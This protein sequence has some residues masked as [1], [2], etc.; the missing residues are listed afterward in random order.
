M[1]TIILD[2]HSFHSLLLPCKIFP[3]GHR[4]VSE[5]VVQ[6]GAPHSIFGV[7]DLTAATSSRFSY[8]DSF[9]DRDIKQLPPELHLFCPRQND[10]DFD[11]YEQEILVDG[12]ECRSSSAKEVLQKI[13]DAK[14]RRAKFMDAMGLIAYD[15]PE[16]E[17]FKNYIWKRLNE[18]LSKCDLCIP[19]YYVAK[20]DMRD[21][22]RQQFEEDDIKSY[23]SII[24]NVDIE[25]I[26]K[27]LDRAKAALQNVPEQKRNLSCLDQASLYSIFEALSCEAF[28]SNES[29]LQNHFDEPFKLIQGKR[30]LKTRDYV[31]AATRFLFD[32]D[33]QRFNWA[34]NAWAKF[35]RA[36]TDLEW[37]W[38]MKE[39]LQTRFTQTNEERSPTAVWRL[40]NGV[41]FIV[42]RLDQQQITHHLRGLEPDISKMALEHLAIKTSGLKFIIETVKSLLEKAPNDFWDAMGSIS[43][44]TVV[45]QIFSS[46]HYEKL[47]QESS[48]VDLAGEM[49]AM[50]MISWISPFLSSLKP[51]NQP[52][53][54]RALITQLFQRAYGPYLT[55]EARL[56][57]HKTAL[58]TLL[59]ILRQFVDDPELRHSVGKVVLSDTLDIVG[60]QI[61]NIV[62]RSSRGSSSRDELEEVKV[63]AMDVVRNAL[64]L[65]CQSL[66]ADFQKL[67]SGL[68]LQQE[69]S[70]YTPEIWS[71]VVQDLHTDDTKL[72][73]AAIRGTHA[74]PGLERII[75]RRSKELSKESMQYNDVFDKVTSLLKQILERIADFAPEHLDHLYKTQET[76][77]PLIAALF[78]ADHGTTLAAN[79]LVKNVSGQPGQ[80]EALAHLLRAFPGTTLYSLSWSFRRIAS[81]RTFGSIARLLKTGMD[82]LDILTDTQTG[83][84]RGSMLESRDIHAAKSYWQ[85]Q[86]LAL[87]TVFRETE[88]WH[89][90]HHD[91]ALMTEVCRD[92]MQYAEALFE[93]YDVFA[94]TI[95]GMKIEGELPVDKVLLENTSG[96]PASSLQAM[97]KW[98]RLRDEYL[99]ATLVK[100][101]TK[102][103]RR[104]S[105]HEIKVPVEAT[106][107]I[108]EVAVTNTVK[109]MLSAQQKAE[110]VRAL[111]ICYKRRIVPEE[112]AKKQ[113]SLAAWTQQKLKKD[114]L[115]SSA[116]ASCE[117]SVDEFDDADVADKDLYELSKSLEISK[118]RLAGLNKT[119]KSVGKIE[120]SVKPE[121]PKQIAKVPQKPVAPQKSKQEVSAFLETR[122]KETEARKARDREAAAQL[123]GRIGIGQQTK[124]QGSGLNGIG[125]K[126]K[127]HSTAAESIMVSSESDSD[128]EDDMELYGTK[129]GVVKQTGTDLFPGRLKGFARLQQGPVKKIKRLLHRNDMRARLAPDL[130]RL[131]QTILGWDFFQDS[132]LPPNSG[133]GDYTLVSNT[134]STVLDYQK[135]FEPL[136]ILEGWQSFRSAREE[137]NFKAF[138]I[139]V[140]NRLSVDSSIELSTNMSI[141]EG[142]ELGLGPADVLL[143]S[144][145][146]QPHSAS[147]QPHC[148]ARVKEKNVKQG[149][150]EIVLRINAANNPLLAT[151]APGTSIWGVQLLSLTPLERE[152]GALKALEFY[153][154][155]EEVINAKPSPILNYSEKEL[156]PLV[157]NY[158]V[159]I[160]QAKAVRS[161]LDN[162]A[163][164]LIQGPPGSGKTK[165]I[166]AMVGAMMTESTRNKAATISRPPVSTKGRLIQAPSG[167]P[168]IQ[169]ILIC[170]PSNAAVDELVMR[171]KSGV[172]TS[173]GRNERLSVVRLGRSDAI[174]TNIK[175]VTLEELVNAKLNLAAPKTGNERD[176]HNIM[177]EH[178]DTSDKL[179]ALRVQ[180]DERRAKGEQVPQADTQAFEGLKKK[181]ANLSLEIDKARDKQKTASRDAELERRRIQQSILDSAHIL[182]ATLSGSGHEIFQSLNIEFETVIIDEAAQSIELSALIPLKYGCSKCILVGDPKQLPPTVLSKEAARFQFEQS[183]FARMEKNHSK[184]VHLLDTQYRMHPE[185]SL[186]PSKTFYE[187]R[188]KDGEDM[189]KLRARPWHHASLLA[190]YRFFDVQG[191]QSS[192]SKGHS[193]INSAELEV[194]MQLYDR[195]ITDCRQY[196]FRGKIGII[197]PYK[198][199]LRELRLRFSRRY[200]DG[201][202]SAVEFNTTDAFQGRE[203]E[204][205]IF[206]CVRATT[207]G[208]GFLSDIRRMNV[209]LTRAKCSLWVLGDSKTLVKGEFWKGLITDAKA[210]NLYTDGD[211]PRLLQRPLL[212]ADMMRDDAEMEDAP[213]LPSLS[214]R[215]SIDPTVTDRQST[216]VKRIEQT[217]KAS[218]TRGFHAINETADDP[219]QSNSTAMIRET[220]P[221]QSGF[222]PAESLGENLTSS[223]STSKKTK[224]PTAR[225]PANPTPIRG[226][227]NGPSGGRTGLNDLAKCRMCGSDDHFTHACENTAARSATHGNC[228]RCRSTLHSSLDCSEPR[229]LECGEVGHAQV[230]CHTTLDLRLSAA[231]KERV[232]KQEQDFIREKARAKQ[233]RAEKQLGEHAARIPPVISTVGEPGGGPLTSK[234]SNNLSSRTAA[235]TK[236]KREE[237]SPLDAPR[238][239]KAMRTSDGAVDL[240]G[241]EKPVMQGKAETQKPAIDGGPR[242]SGG[243]SRQSPAGV[244]PKRKAK[245]SDIFLKR[246]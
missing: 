71:V 33:P 116:S 242:L 147:D 44:S 93:Q 88:R 176:I 237:A 89:T 75:N 175:D 167:S 40:W 10:E 106:D 138:E 122:R 232:R 42:R 201:I 28:L 76:S 13:K 163:F 107:Y 194:A 8:A 73:E 111:E 193:L 59:Q 190:P 108:E 203:S 96:S 179:H 150:M 79:D 17:P 231:E 120:K 154:L 143:L 91:K 174:N 25:R 168:G 43:P 103:L 141:V 65:E 98:L 169:K 197:T 100:L 205:I 19:A 159:N 207:K 241:K 219:R 204:I 105:D 130:S 243:T 245:D 36:P 246:K 84:L 184:D 94:S 7:R 53:A 224:T 3:S 12:E 68:S 160:A 31:P 156:Q 110:V 202:L 4:Q 50:Q 227:V 238:G 9:L 15:G 24:D 102:M 173:D 134:F 2:R 208:I 51:A 117:Q 57:C 29:L 244:I 46:P 196:D 177:M 74:L 214:Q 151:L 85:Y 104:L 41:R 114:V 146:S 236:R 230:T 220:T 21:S 58:S 164:T 123:R 132:E 142:K 223:S 135:T 183:L 133:K 206:S 211:V 233:R 186:F 216:S 119:E 158:N 6:Y 185:I 67:S 152:Y 221:F 49:T 39:I 126:G 113:K 1:T 52:P 212:T 209:G 32:A 127:D 56:I 90:L 188:L 80:K 5:G 189:A 162:D 161:A 34:S 228:L 55:D 195:L 14:D 81:M 139:K 18:A 215:P 64:E 47:L 148:M 97:C 78:S 11:R 26:V 180:I 16:T 77:M 166:C 86:W 131:H 157:E 235:D 22:L 170:A 99:S 30:P 136:L 72:S 149:Q 87:K 225:G 92:A 128:T 45:E 145:A 48:K 200:G 69:S 192:T 140:S 62:E 229:C 137:G 37:S 54:C 70:T 171:L 38:T 144:K 82:I 35:D 199:Q 234:P 124:G 218:S 27:G 125:V 101:I 210:R 118:V 226:G 121:L 129:V 213:I 182:C 63:L 60:Q 61:V 23:F 109:T 239:P 153:D 178:K 95:S 155:A 240:T 198:G 20:I 112:P 181:K 66:K 115:D 222:P 172:K 83:F 217:A 165:T 187:S 191:M